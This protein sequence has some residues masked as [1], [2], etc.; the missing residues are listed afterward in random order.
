VSE[1]KAFR[2]PRLQLKRKDLS[3]KHLEDLLLKHIQPDSSNSCD[4][5][6]LPTSCLIPVY[7][8]DKMYQNKRKVRIKRGATY[9]VMPVWAQSSY[10]L[11]LRVQQI[12]HPLEKDHLMKDE[13]Q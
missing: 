11:Q 8:K 3:L 12:W 6:E 10:M 1:I 2:Q 7:N 4:G 9:S 5:R 13:L